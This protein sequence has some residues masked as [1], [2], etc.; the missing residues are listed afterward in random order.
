MPSIMPQE[1]E[2]WYLLP[3]LRRALCSALVDEHNLSQREAADIL[4]I[5]ESAVSQYLKK[6][7]ASNVKFSAAE[8]AR[9]RKAA[10]IILKDKRAAQRQL[11]M[12]C[13]EFRGGTSMCRMHRKHDSYLPKKCKM[14][15]K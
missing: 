6:K 10:A 13:E 11:Y 9:I 3:A 7:R 14:C 1:I 5:T 2:V 8:T 15:V 4:G 12:L